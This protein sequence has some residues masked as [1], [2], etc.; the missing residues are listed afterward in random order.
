[1]KKTMRTN[2]EMLKTRIIDANEVS[3]SKKIKK[4]LE[5]IKDSVICV[6]VG[7]SNVV[8]EY[9]AK[10][11]NAKNDCIAINQDPRDFLY[12]NINNYKNVF[13]C[14]YSGKNYGVKVALEN[15][16]KKYLFTNGNIQKHD[17][18]LIKY[19]SNIEEEHSFISLAATLMP[20]SILLHYYV[21]R[22]F[23]TLLN[24]MF[25][26]IS[27]FHFSSNDT[28]EIMS[29]YDTSVSAKY[30][31]STMVE[32]GLA[33]PIIHSKY[34]FC[35]G[36]TTLSY[37][38]N[39]TLIFLQSTDNELDKLILEQASSLYKEIII[40]KSSYNDIIIDDFNLTLKS[41]YLTKYLSELKHI[42]LS[43]IEYAPAVKK[44]YH[45]KGS[46]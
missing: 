22:R 32:A 33:N 17:I 8:S 46:M 10:V 14:S 13:V 27:N 5:N 1:M 9:A 40:L 30:L 37:K 20:M 41:L 28:F 11:F 15:D 7:G 6:G 39:H 45:F 12:K 29:G 42:D 23:R 25:D 35:H 31:E 2:F 16:L 26:D 34:S 24:Q 44:L 36:R 19:E 4:E 43:N 38:S 3:D 21:G 18:S